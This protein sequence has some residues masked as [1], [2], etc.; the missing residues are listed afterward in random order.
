[1]TPN[2]PLGLGRLAALLGGALIMGGCQSQPALAPLPPV[3]EAASEAMLAAW[4][5]SRTSGFERGSPSFQEAMELAHAAAELAPAWTAPERFLDRWHHRLGLSLPD[6]YADHLAGAELGNGRAAYLAARLGGVGGRR[7]LAQ[8][9]EVAPSLAWPWHGVAWT[10][11]REGAMDQ[12]VAAGRNAIT[13]ARDPSEL[14]LFSWAMATYLE[15]D[16]SLEAAAAVLEAAL[17]ETGALTLRAAER[18]MVEVRLAGVL[19]KADDAAR[20]GKGVRLATSTLASPLVTAGERRGLVEA[21]SEVGGGLVS[22]PEVELALARVLA[23]LE[24][25]DRLEAARLLRS[26]REGG[27]P[28]TSS[29]AWRAR[30]AQGFREDSSPAETRVLLLEWAADLP[31][32]V[33][34]A[35]GAP[36]DPV[37]AALVDSVRAGAVGPRSRESDRDVA[38]QLL[39]AG[40]FT[41]AIGWSGR[42]AEGDPEGAEAVELAGLQGR[43]ALAALL[44][45][46]RR[47]DATAA[48]ASAAGA[49]RKVESAADLHNEVA[50][51]LER[52]GWMEIPEGGVRSPVIGY[53]PAGS[54][55]HPGPAF[56][57]EDGRLGRGTPGDQVPGLAAAFQ[58]MGRFAL[59][60]RGAGQGGPDATVLRRLHAEVREGTHLGRPF[61]GTVVWC[62]GADVPGRFSR[63]G[64]AIAG[65][66]LHEGYY[67]DLQVIAAE[68]EYWR[69]LRSRFLVAAETPDLQALGSALVA[70]APSSAR[71]DEIAPALGAADR[72][73]LAVMWEP[74]GAS[75]E[76]PGLEDFC[77]GVA[78]H[79]EAHLCDRMAWYPL[80]ATRVLRLLAFAGGQGFSGARISEAIEER[81]QLVAMASL[82]D[83]RLLWVDLLD[84]AEESLG[85][86]GAPHG[87]AYRRLLGRLLRRMQRESLGGGWA[88]LPG[89][90]ARLV[91]RLHL[92]RPEALRA[93]ALREARSMGLTGPGF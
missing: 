86:G 40:W 46:G 79:E 53:G 9:A 1:M 4:T 76:V 36:R 57:D 89:R 29:S 62:Q 67:L 55:V 84:A 17:S 78:A 2:K 75:L 49:G 14:A 50:R 44:N 8:A 72:L 47:L 13:L 87:R 23:E 12:A 82:E 33:V 16:G 88:D 64:G 51:I 27:R 7:G 90:G 63:R 26:L 42:M 35:E 3:D 19:L 10:A 32:A 52:T 48:F 37:L 31:G 61:R 25:A 43:A 83:P 93:L 60:G 58:E 21:L 28:A 59:V 70:P 11:S 74:E 56:S 34:D 54:I 66:A 69:A 65:A 92:A 18:G 30:L 77:A 91:D 85:G 20:Q 41:E 68:R 38:A 24:G 6:R 73:R 71:P 39:A 5:L 81:A 45:L 22:G 15:A 80:T